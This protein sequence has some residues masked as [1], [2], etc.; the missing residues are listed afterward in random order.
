MALLL[1]AACGAPAVPLDDAG[2]M[3]DAGEFDAGEVDA[4]VPST[5]MPGPIDAGPHD[6]GC[7]RRGWFPDIDADG[8][9]SKLSQPVIACDAPPGHV[10]N[11]GDCAD[12][13]PRANPNQRE[14]QST[15]IVGPNAGK[16]FDFDCS[17][18]EY[19]ED[20]PT[21]L[22]YQST[23]SCVLV[24]GKRNFWATKPTTCGA[25]GEWILRCESVGM[26]CSK[27]VEQRVARCR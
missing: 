3:F 26:M 4:G 21:G 2:V 13:D 8:F 19:F 9:G 10:P 16:P 25:T 23:S 7:I 15:A 22:C 14:F 12:H 24:I 27:D 5:P 1:L 17:G 18:F 20:L 6:A 11:N